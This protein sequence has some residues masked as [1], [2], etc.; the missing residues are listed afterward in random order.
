MITRLFFISDFLPII[1]ESLPR[2]LALK[3]DPTEKDLWFLPLGGT[4][5]IVMNINLYRHNGQWLMIDCGVRFFT[6]LKGKL[7]FKWSPLSSI[8]QR[9]VYQ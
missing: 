6:E 2:A 9:T 7:P 8:T 3:Y 1:I 5:E 4:G